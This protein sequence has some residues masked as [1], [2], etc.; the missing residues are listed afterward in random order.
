MQPTT[1]LMPGFV[2]IETAIALIKKDKREEA[3]VDLQFLAN[4]IPYMKVKQVYN[5]RLM[6]T[7]TD[8]KTGQRKAVR[9]GSVYV[10]IA[11]EYD[12]QILLKA[13]S[14]AFEERTKIQLN[15]DNLGLN[16]VTSMVD[17]EAEMTDARPRGNYNSTIKAGDDISKPYEQVLQGV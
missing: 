9:N 8:K 4:N 11:T 7:I 2:T 10:T 17:E 15:V 14:D 5:I 6:K 1:N 16:R 12:R 3:T 13:I